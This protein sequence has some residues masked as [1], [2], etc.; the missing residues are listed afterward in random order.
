MEETG[1]ILLALP[2]SGPPKNAH[3]SSKRIGWIGSVLITWAT[4]LLGRGAV[5]VFCH[6]GREFFRWAFCQTKR[7]ASS[8]NYFPRCVSHNT[9][10]TGDLHCVQLA[11]LRAPVSAR[12]A[13]AV[14][15]QA[16][17]HR[18][19]THKGVEVTAFYACAFAA[20]GRLHSYWHAAR[21]TLRPLSLAQD[22]FRAG[23]CVLL[24][25]VVLC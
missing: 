9:A 23:T 19:S 11:A 22:Y 8:P 3:P 10:C 15:L 20:S 7:L 16:G 21:P 2:H 4:C 18:A 17:H 5:H 25:S 12:N 24:P 1:R 13:G 6:V 14:M